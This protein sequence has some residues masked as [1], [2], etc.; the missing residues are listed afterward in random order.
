MRCRYVRAV[1]V[2]ML[3]VV[4]GGVDTDMDVVMRMW[5]ADTLSQNAVCQVR[6]QNTLG[7]SRLI[8]ARARHLPRTRQPTPLILPPPPPLSSLF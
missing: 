4:H 7:V 6:H 8:Q 1:G 2:G 5:N 3:E